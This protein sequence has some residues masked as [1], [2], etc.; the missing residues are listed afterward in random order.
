MPFGHWKNFDA[1]LSQMEGQ[2]GYS[3][4]S[5]HKVC[6]KLKANLE[7]GSELDWGKKQERKEVK[8]VKQKEDF[9]A[10]PRGKA[11]A[12]FRTT[13]AR[14]K[15]DP[16]SR[17]QA[18]TWTDEHGKY[19]LSKDTPSSRVADQLHPKLDLSPSDRPSKRSHRVYDGTGMPKDIRR[20]GKAFL[21]FKGWR[22]YISKPDMEKIPEKVKEVVDRKEKEV[23]K[24]CPCEGQKIEMEHADTLMSLGV[25]EDKIPEAAKKIAA[26]HVKEDPEYY[27]HLKEMEGKFA[28]DELPKAKPKDAL[29]NFLSGKNDNPPVPQYSSDTKPVSKDSSLGGKLGGNE[30]LL[31]RGYTRQ[32]KRELSE[33]REKSRAEETERQTGGFEKALEIDKIQKADEEQ[34]DEDSEIRQL[35]LKSKLSP[36]VRD[37]KE[38]TVQ[39]DSIK[40]WDLDFEAML[41]SDRDFSGTF[42]KPV[43][44]KENDII[45]ASAMDR[46]MDD[47]MVL[48]TLQEVHTERTVGIITKAWKTSED[49]YKFEGKIKP[50]EDCNDVWNKIKKGEY[51]GLSIGGR[52]I[53]YSKECSIPSAIRDSPCVTQK[54]KLYNVSVCSSPVNPEASVDDVNK[55]AKGGN[56]DDLTSYQKAETTQSG[57]CHPTYDGTKKKGE[58][59]DEVENSDDVITKSDISD[60]TKAIDDLTKSFASHFASITTAQPQSLGGKKAK[61]VTN[62]LQKAESDDE[63]DEEDEKPMRVKKAVDEVEPDESIR[64]AYDTKISELTERIAKM[65]AEK[66]QKGATAI[67]IPEQLGKNDPIL[68]NTQMFDGYGR[69]AK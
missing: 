59:M 63:E 60:L 62:T 54:L 66:I 24:E 14:N 58:N 2:E 68:S 26:D 25:P 49:E 15:E 3:S 29:K 17:H 48:P 42:H 36:T 30:S 55:V 20:V 69:T 34:V 53:K 22:D 18:T 33:V 47:F 5:A 6:G 10:S 67:I 1:C 40:D 8:A 16:N 21:F 51:D 32:N 19:K 35:R 43:V 11:L 41:K 61:H 65:E 45:P 56:G 46:A 57:L 9:D 13:V 7:K 37:L 28:K 27:K 23:K 4:E 64:K 44:D 38:L 39:K 52:R 50:G 31:F 12:L